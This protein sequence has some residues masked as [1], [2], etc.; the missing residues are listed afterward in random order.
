MKVTNLK[1]FLLGVLFCL[2]LLISLVGSWIFLKFQEGFVYFQKSLPNN[3]MITN[4]GKNISL[5]TQ[6]RNKMRDSVPLKLALLGLKYPISPEPKEIL[7]INWYSNN[8][9]K[10][11]VLISLWTCFSRMRQSLWLWSFRQTIKR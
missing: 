7:S 10:I 4:F 3:R 6:N 9:N 11:L 1:N 5:F 2:C 8:K